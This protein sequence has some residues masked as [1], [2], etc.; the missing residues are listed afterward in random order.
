MHS[1]HDDTKHLILD[2]VIPFLDVMFG[3]SASA[4][5]ARSPPL[6]LETEVSLLDVIG[7]VWLT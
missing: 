7:C 4:S 1:Q 3:G 2:A 6:Q 5:I